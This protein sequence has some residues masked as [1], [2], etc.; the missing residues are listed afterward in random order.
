MPLS[1]DR[2]SLGAIAVLAIVSANTTNI[3]PQQPRWYNK[4]L[5]LPAARRT[6]CGTI[7]LHTRRT[8]WLQRLIRPK[9]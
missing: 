8:H 4:R 5:S 9:H 1:P 3:A 2:Q 6:R 7:N